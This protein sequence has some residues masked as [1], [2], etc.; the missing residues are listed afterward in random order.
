MFFKSYDRTGKM[1]Y[2]LRALTAL[3]EDQVLFPVPTSGGSQPHV[4]PALGDPVTSG[5]YTHGQIPTHRH[6]CLHIS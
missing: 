1:V 6:T 5:F 2:I 3:A 4:T